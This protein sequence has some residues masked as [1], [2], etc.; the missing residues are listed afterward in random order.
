MEE[1]RE[2]DGIWFQ[3]DELKIIS[4]SQSGSIPDLNG[5]DLSE[6]SIEK[7][8][9]LMPLHERQL[10]GDIIVHIIQS[11]SAEK[12]RDENGDEE[13]VKRQTERLMFHGVLPCE[14]RRG[15]RVKIK[16]KTEYVI[17]GG[18]R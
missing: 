16:R 9:S 2:E 17:G 10:T 6:L 4:C 18:R 8:R 7:R 15:M 1:Y 3:C 12:E 13:S 11:L 5:G 14:A